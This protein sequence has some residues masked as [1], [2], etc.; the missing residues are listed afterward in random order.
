ML[1]LGESAHHEWNTIPVTEHAGKTG[2]ALQQELHAGPY[3]I[4]RVRY[5]AHYRAD[6]WCDRGHIVLVVEGRVRIEF[7]DHPVVALSSGHVF[8]VSDGTDRH[9]MYTESGAELYIVDEH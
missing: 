5:S 3:R 6:H 7:P 8:W 1:L 2:I 9:R 4:R